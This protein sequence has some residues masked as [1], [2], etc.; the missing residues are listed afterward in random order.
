MGIELE[1]ADDIA[2]EDV[3][4]QQ[5]AMIVQT[6]QQ[7]YPSIAQHI[8]GHSDIA[9]QRKTDPGDAFDWSRFW[10]LIGQE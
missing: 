4:Y 8:T 9:P 7:H 1:G 5:L 10:Q 2:Y 6:L 3:Q